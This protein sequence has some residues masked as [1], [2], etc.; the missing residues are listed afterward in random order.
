MPSFQMVNITRLFFRKHF[1]GSHSFPCQSLLLSTT[2][3]NDIYGLAQLHGQTQ[4]FVCSLLELRSNFDECKINFSDM[5]T[6]S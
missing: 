3:L 5:Q 1:S 4:I 2:V 6:C